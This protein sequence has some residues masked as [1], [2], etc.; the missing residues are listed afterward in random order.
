MQ[1]KKI[2]IIVSI[3]LLIPIILAIHFKIYEDIPKEILEKKYAQSPSQFIDIENARVHYRDEGTGPVLVLLHGIF[4]SLHTWDGWVKE[5]SGKYRIIRL[6]LPAHGLT[7]PVGFSYSRKDYTRF[8]HSFFEKLNLKKIHL[9]GNSLGGYFSWAYT[10]YHPENVKKLILLN[11][12]GFNKK[13]PIAI[14]LF[15]VPVLGYF[16]ERIT[17]KFIFSYLIKG[18]Y[19]NQKKLT[20]D[21]SD[22]YYDLILYPGNRTAY[23]KLIYILGEEMSEGPR[24]LE[25]ITA[26][27]L[28]MWGEKDSWIPV[29]NSKKFSS[30]LRNSKLII[31]GQAGHIPMEEIPVETARDADRFLSGK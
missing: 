31:Y 11:S 30:S 22:R 4:S 21:T 9:A 6:D 27:V 8:L 13:I 10:L 3:L 1:K 5:L 14:Q 19:G 29:S 16:T 28:I 20:L 18:V 2:I 23:R 7:G 15:T 25:N 26:P 12:V 24:G 17:Y